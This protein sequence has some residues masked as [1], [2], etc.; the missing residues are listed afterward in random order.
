MT[1]VKIPFLERFREPMLNG[2]KTMTSRTK[3]Y[4]GKGDVFEAFGQTFAIESVD[5]QPFVVI[6]TQWKVEGCDSKEDFLAVWKQIH[7]RKALNPL[8][9]F[10]V[11]RFHK[12]E[13]T[14]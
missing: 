3:I 2:T 11:H 12:L 1:K 7:P 4:G 8:D 9:I 10:F 5:L 14:P 13:A 6:A